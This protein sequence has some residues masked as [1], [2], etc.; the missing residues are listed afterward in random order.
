MSKDRS[1][2]NARLRVLAIALALMALA[3]AAWAQD[4]A[5]P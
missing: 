2:R 1:H 4:A 5:K 3:P